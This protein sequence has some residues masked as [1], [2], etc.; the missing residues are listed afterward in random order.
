MDNARTWNLSPAL[1]GPPELE[2]LIGDLSRMDIAPVGEDDVEERLSAVV[3]TTLR[4]TS[5]VYVCLR[6]REPP[7][8][9]ANMPSRQTGDWV[10]HDG[11]PRFE[12]LLS[13]LQW[14]DATAV[15]FVATPPSLTAG[16]MAAASAPIVERVGH[17]A[18]SLVVVFASAPEGGVSAFPQTLGPLLEALAAQA[19]AALVNSRLQAKL[20]EARFETVFRL[21]VAAEYRDSETAAHIQ[22]MS[23]YAEAIARGMGLSPA[24]VELT[25]LSSPMHDV[26]KLGIPDA[27]LM[28]TGPLNEEEW[29][30]MRMHTRIGAEILARSDSPLLR[31]SEQVAL[32]HHEKFGGHG[33]PSGLAG[34]RIPLIGR[35]ASLGDAFDAIT[36][37]RCYKA[38]SSLEQGLEI[39]TEDAGS[40]FD[41]ECV[42]AL[43]S[44]EADVAAIHRLWSDAARGSGGRG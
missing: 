10:L 4:A 16:P 30:V 2:S 18:G 37:P 39:V 19:A 13:Q 24:M 28:K 31:A 17:V 23:R 41:P 8:S 43:V 3:T 1:G 11:E 29:R 7:A 5:A 15:Q 12:D 33:Y 22:R 42:A 21:S 9:L 38:A 14:T 40:H 36:S 25:Q 20:R 35:I 6:L 27:I 26:G 44:L 32:T 34:D